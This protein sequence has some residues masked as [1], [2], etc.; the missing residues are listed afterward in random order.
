MAD[1]AAF[2]GT[3]WAFPPAFSKGGADVVMVSGAEDVQQSLQ[4]LFATELDERPMRET[5]GASLQRLVFEEIDPA[6]IA[7]LRRAVND[8]V[9]AYEP[10][11]DLEGVEVQADPVVDGM[12]LISLLYKLRGSN[13]RF[14][15][16]FPFYVREAATAR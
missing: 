8:A 2:L 9:I 15:F 3:G 6:L 14:N 1:N 11:I 12:L 5:F 16:V 10:R 13:S 4:I 7:S